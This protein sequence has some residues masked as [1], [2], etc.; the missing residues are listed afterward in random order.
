MK[1]NYDALRS[2]GF[3]KNL[4]TITLM[5][6]CLISFAFAQ[7]IDV[8][9]TVKDENSEALP[10][11]NIVIEGTTSGTV[12]DMDGNYS[13]SVPGSESVLV[14]SSIGYVTEQIRVGDQSVINLSMSQDITSL[15]E[16]VVV[17]YGTQNRA[18]VTGAISSV[19]ADEITAVPTANISQAL[20]GR[21]SGV[22]VINNGSPG[23]SPTIRIRGLGTTGNNTPLYVVDGVISSSIDGLN[24]NDIESIEVLKDASTTAV[25]GSK[26]S[27]GVI[28]IT[29]KKGKSGDVVVSANAYAGSQWTNKRF[30]LLN[31]DQYIQ[32]ATEAFGAPP[33]MTDPQYASLLE[34]DTD[35]QEA[36]FQSGLM[37]NY[38]VAVSG[39]GQNSNF[40]VSAGYLSQEGVI[41][42]SGMDR[43]NFRANSNFT[44]G[45]FSFGE[46]ISVAFGELRPYFNSGG[47]SVLEHAIKMAPYLPIYEPSNLGGYRGPNTAID[48]QDAENPVR[49]LENPNA[50][51]DQFNLIGNLYAQYEFIDGLVF[52]TQVGLEY[53]TL[54]YNSII[55]SYDD[56]LEGG[57][58]Q[59]DHADI[60]KRR[61]GLQS[62]ILTNS[63]N[64]QKTFAEKHNL[65]VLLLAESTS[66]EITT[67]NTTS[68]N[69][70][71]ND[72]EQVDNTNSN[73]SSTLN[74]YFRLGFLGR[75]NYNY[76]SRYIVSASFRRD[77]S[78]RFGANYRWGTF[79]SASVGWRISEEAFMTNVTAVSN[80]KF[81]ASWGLT[82]NDNIPDY[83]YTTG[84]QSNFH[85][86]IA[87]SDALGATISGLSNPDL[88]WEEISMLNFGL[89]FGLFADQITLSAEYYNN[90]SDDL[91]MPRI[92]PISSGFHNGSVIEN[93]GSM[94]NKGFEFNLGYNDF[95]GEFQWSGSLNLGTNKNEVLNLGE[96]DAIQGGNFESENISW[97]TVGNPLFQFYGWQFDGIFQNQEEVNNYMG[98]SQASNLNAEPGDFRI[99]DANN[100]GVINAEDR[101]F[102]GNPFPKFSYGLNL[103]ATYKGFDFDLFF[104]GISGVDVY[105]TNIYDL[106]AMPRLFN[107]G[108]GVL[109]RWTGPGTSN[110]VPRAGGAATNAQASSR[111]VENGSY[112]R[113]RN[114]SIGYDLASSILN[115]KIS[116]FR[117]YVSAQNLFTITDYSGLDPEVGQYD[118]VAAGVGPSA[119]GTVATNANGQPLVNFQ[120]GIDLGNYPMPKSFI[121][122]VQIQF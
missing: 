78:S 100:D 55:P 74:E 18:D 118:G 52:K 24:Q 16:I 48:G 115:G 26:G 108:V 83:A 113:L 21:A 32:Y 12:S 119:P 37:Q 95:E 35:W 67:L 96:N 4:L 53:T 105:N 104:N 69:F 43:Y 121:G 61:S 75:I 39:G 9:G 45:N 11:V 70:I 17:G 81:R 3:L 15:S 111:Y 22:T 58:H 84:V 94:E 66:T 25:Y 7:E 31:T 59:Q 63:L 44:L 57:T 29:T 107:S 30:D 27:N 65:E 47:R 49:V 20:Q 60:A 72:V 86:P 23:S 99:V 46:N 93:V 33:R 19:G 120:T 8:T 114:V 42:N 90:Q 71:T 77:A 98:G 64:Y 1:N 92:L 51:T 76:D 40:R 112:T 36:I 109:N 13:I 56:D 87:G 117:I 5:Q 122:G 85:Y 68:E 62:I 102:I 97:T 14:F 54:E 73:L 6:L 89:D 91:L 82:G 10:G 50:Q 79:P 103:T 34:N 41:L 2:K 88:K 110:T 38:D 116:K 28:M 80:L 101:T 106:E